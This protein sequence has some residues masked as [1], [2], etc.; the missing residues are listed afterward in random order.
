M[1]A[2]GR[3]W[4]EGLAA[5]G[6]CGQHAGLATG[7]SACKCM[8]LH[9]APCLPPSVPGAVFGGSPVAI[10]SSPLPLPSPSP[11]PQPLRSGSSPRPSPIPLR[12]PYASPSLPSSSAVGYR[13]PS[14]YADFYTRLSEGYAEAE[15]YRSAVLALAYTA[16]GLFF[17]QVLLSLV[18]LYSL[19]THPGGER[20]H[21]KTCG[22]AGS[23]HR[24]GPAR[25]LPIAPAHYSHMHERSQEGHCECLESCECWE[26]WELHLRRP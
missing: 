17:L 25:R 2:L 7:A 13:P 5:A 24:G 6:S 19:R 1:L 26:P 16:A 14:Y 21:C 18:A 23:G 9:A 10:P 22:K 8:P 15:G 20:W 4:K 12:G 3:Q 11:S